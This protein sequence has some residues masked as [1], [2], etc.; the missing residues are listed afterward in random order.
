MSVLDAPPELAD[1]LVGEAPPSP[2]GPA[3]DDGRGVRLPP[4]L[5]LPRALQTL[6]FSVRQI[7]YVFRARRELGDVFLFRGTFGDDDVVTCHPDHVR[8][9]FTAKPE[10]A[11]SLTGESPL[12][13]I[14]GPNSVL[15][16]VGPRHMRQRKLLLPPFHG[17]AVQR[18][19][20][21]IAEAAEREIGRW[22]LGTPFQLAPRMQAITLD[23]IMAGIFGV[24]GQPAP[25]TPEEGL[26]R[27]I[28]QMVALSTRPEAQLFE[29]L[30]LASDEP[31]GPLR[32]FLAQLDKHVYAV[33]AARREDERERTDILSLLLG[34]E[35]EEGER[36]TDQ[37]L[38]DE[39]LT[40]VLAGH[41]T[42]ANSLA[43]A[44][45]RLL[46]HP[47]AYDRLRDVSRSS[48]DEEGYVEAVIHETMRSRPVIPIIGRR[49]KVPWQLGEH[50]V[51]AETPVLMS[52]LLLHHREDVYPDPFAFRPERFVGVKPGTYTWIPFG[53][54]IRRCL[55]AALAMAEQRVVMEAVALRTDLVA[56]DPVPERAVH[57]NVT[58]IPAR[59]TRVIVR[60][61]RA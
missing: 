61:R 10:E 29:L 48:A 14:V 53:G 42:T 40:L 54:G 2:A 57:R 7:E 60:A 39:L 24:Q 28:R 32:A 1:G 37:E 3:P 59:G 16:A 4:S 46:R 56:D 9:L 8:S 26:R 36:L 52:I 51:P 38:R 30:N 23:V 50:R 34:A 12:R 55:G 6:R 19:T 22:P 43:W 20:E 41:E 27:Q 15:T 17:E 25:G 44:F 13:P 5:P 21:M 35:T 31:L 47:A 18:Y 58:M 49:V 11:P 33:I 45:E